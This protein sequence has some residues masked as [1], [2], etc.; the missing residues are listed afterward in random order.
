[1]FG[2]NDMTVSI[3]AWGTP[4]RQRNDAA[5]LTGQATAGFLTWFERYAR[6]GRIQSVVERD[7][8]G[9]QAQDPTI[10]VRALYRG[11]PYL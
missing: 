7:T 11:K 9:P 1:M 6:A 2:E 4:R 10:S 5:E 3:T 8:A